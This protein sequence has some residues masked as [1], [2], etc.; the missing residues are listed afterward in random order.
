MSAWC[1]DLR[2]LTT[3]DTEF[4]E[5]WCYGFIELGLMLFY[6]LIYYAFD[7]YFWVAFE[8]Y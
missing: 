8:I 3:E 1:F 7:G 5:A 6:F 2:C 4:T